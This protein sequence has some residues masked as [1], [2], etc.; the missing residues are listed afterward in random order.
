MIDTMPFSIFRRLFF[1]IITRA[2]LRERL[3]AAFAYCCVMSL[4]FAAMLTMLFLP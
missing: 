2:M 3:A 4:L 1:A